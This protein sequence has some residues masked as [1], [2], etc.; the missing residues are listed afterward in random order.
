GK[1]AWE[2]LIAKYQN[3]SKQRRW[4]LMR[5]LDTLTISQ[6]EDTDVFLPSL[7]QINDEFTNMNESVSDER[8]TDIVIEG[9]T[10][11]YSQI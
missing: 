7:C 10:D 4:I 8:L 2:G 6:D 5:Q 1:R 11:D 9:L 3:S